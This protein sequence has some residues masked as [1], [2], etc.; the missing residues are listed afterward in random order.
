MSHRSIFIK[1]QLS[2]LR[3]L[4][5]PR[6]CRI[7]V[8]SVKPT[9]LSEEK[10][11][12]QPRACRSTSRTASRC[13]TRRVP[14]CPVSYPRVTRRLRETLQPNLASLWI[15]LIFVLVL[16]PGQVAGTFLDTAFFLL[17]DYSN[18]MY[19]HAGNHLAACPLRRQAG[20]WFETR[21]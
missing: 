18:V 12:P 14:S 4:H 5:P 19:T 2:L 17:V 11:N 20:R 7:A 3:S 8:F 21:G 13:D 16:C 1:T 9:F 10:S 6:L 15:C